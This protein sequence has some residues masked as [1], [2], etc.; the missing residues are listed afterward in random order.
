MGTK[1]SHLNRYERREI[2]TMQESGLKIGVIARKLKRSRST[3]SRDLKRNKGTG[4][5]WRYS[6]PLEQANLA[7]ETAKERQVKREGQRR[8]KLEDNAEL[9][10][11]VLRLLEC[12][13]NPQSPE[14][15]ALLLSQSDLGVKLSGKTIRRFINKYYPDYR[16]HFPLRDKRPRKSLTPGSK[17]GKLA[18]A[19][20]A[21]RSISERAEEV[22]SRERNGDFEADLIVCKQSKSVV[23]S[24]RERKTRYEIYRLLPNKEAGTVRRE[25]ISIFNE[26]PPHLRKT[27]TFDRGGEFSETHDFEKLFLMKSYFCDAYCAWQKGGVE[28]QNRG[29]RRDF[30][31]GTDFSKLTQAQLD[32]VARKRNNRLVQCL[33]KLSPLQAWIIA[34]RVGKTLLH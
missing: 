25:L 21:K 14:A 26:I 9:Q 30:P 32:E 27:I 33:G 23:L 6:T 11:R 12:E 8:C 29:F 22:N 15:I 1:Y 19:A 5:A 28:N 18:Q 3:V 7:H 17:R 20:P 16:K 31:K 13:E 10:N 24:V 4:Y 34:C 2:Y